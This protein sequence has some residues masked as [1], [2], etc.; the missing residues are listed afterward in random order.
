MGGH[1]SDGQQLWAMRDGL[2]VSQ[3]FFGVVGG[4]SKYTVRLRDWPA[5][6]LRELVAAPPIAEEFD[7]AAERWD[8][9]RVL[10]AESVD[11][12]ATRRMLDAFRGRHGNSEWLASCDAYFT[13]IWEC[14]WR[15]AELK[16][17]R[18]ESTLNDRALCS[19]AEAAV[20]ARAG[21]D[22]STAKHLASMRSE[23]AK[24]SPFLDLTFRDIGQRIET[25]LR[26]GHA[27]KPSAPPAQ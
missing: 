26:A 2:D 17:W 19:A 13:A 16:L 7:V 24:R 25:V 20:A 6:L 3:Y 1:R 9:G 15:A 4:C 11:V 8:I 14:D 12:V 5:W 23:I 10:D 21:D 27:I 18:A 22:N